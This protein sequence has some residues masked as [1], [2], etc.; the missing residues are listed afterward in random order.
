MARLPVIGADG[1][2]WGGILEDF[3]S[4]AH[5]PDGSLKTSLIVAG[6]GGAAASD[7]DVVHKA[8][9]E[10]ITGA[11]TFT[12]ANLVI[13]TVGYGLQVKEGS[14]AKQGV[15]TLV[16]GTVTVANTS[17]TAISRILLTV[18]SL[19]TVTAPKAIGVTARTAG[20]NFTITSADNTDTSVVAYE[21]FEPA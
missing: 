18:Q 19:G 1:N 7:A 3:L 21:I 5:N 20:T 9:V 13:G 10:T 4:I 17:V 14:N 11:K 15:A 16:G 8:G 2:A 12:S 6:S